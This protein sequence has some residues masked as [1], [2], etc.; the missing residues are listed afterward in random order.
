MP[1]L[2]RRHHLQCSALVLKREFLRAAMVMCI[3]TWRH[4]RLLC[5]RYSAFLFSFSKLHC[6]LLAKGLFHT[7]GPIVLY[8]VLP[9]RFSAHFEKYTVLFLVV[10]NL[11][12]FQWWTSELAYRKTHQVGGALVI[13]NATFLLSSLVAFVYFPPSVR[14]SPLGVG[15]SKIHRLS[16]GTTCGQLD[17]SNVRVQPGWKIKPSVLTSWNCFSGWLSETR[18]ASPT[19]TVA[20][21]I[22]VIIL[23][24]CSLNLSTFMLLTAHPWPSII[25]GSIYM[26][27]SFNFI[28]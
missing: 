11:L 14:V 24:G 18:L 5:F 7:I 27:L 1:L 3:L 10:V 21:D 17:C 16:R 22:P 8:E 12:I 15:P 13:Q 23:F 2:Y 19:H 25:F 6:P 28:H 4:Y 26:F 20:F 9:T